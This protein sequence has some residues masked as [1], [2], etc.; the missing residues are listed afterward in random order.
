[1]D[2]PAFNVSRQAEAA[3]AFEKIKVGHAGEL[4]E[5]SEGKK[6]SGLNGEKKRFDNGRNTGRIK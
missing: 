4:Y 2:L 1:M 5:F 6:G 3:S